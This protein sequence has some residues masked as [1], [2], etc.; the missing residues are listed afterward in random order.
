MAIIVGTFATAGFSSVGY[1]A[2]AQEAEANLAANANL[3]LTDGNAYVS[4]EGIRFAEFTNASPAKALF[5]AGKSKYFDL[6]FS[7][8]YE[9]TSSVDY[10]TIGIA[11]GMKEKD[12]GQLNTSA[13]SPEDGGR[14]LIM[15]G[16]I[17]NSAKCNARYLGGGTTQIV[18]TGWFKEIPNVNVI[19]GNEHKVTLS[20]KQSGDNFKISLSV[21]GAALEE[22]NYPRNWDGGSWKINCDDLGY[23]GLFTETNSSAGN[24]VIDISELKL[25]SYDDGNGGQIE[26]GNPYSFKKS[27][28]DTTNLAI[29][30]NAWKIA[31]NGKTTVSYEQGLRFDSFTSTASGKALFTQAKY[32]NFDLAVKFKYTD[33]S[34]VDDHKLLGVA[35]G[36]QSTDLAQL[37]IDGNTPSPQG[38]GRYA[39]VVGK[40]YGFE[41]A[42]WYRG[43]DEKVTDSGA[44]SSVTD[45]IDG[46][47]HSLRITVRKQSASSSD[48]WMNV[49][50]DNAEV[51]KNAYIHGKLTVDG[52]GTVTY[53]KPGYI[54]LF[55]ETNNNSGNTAVEISDVQIVSYDEKSCGESVKNYVSGANLGAMVRLSEPS[56]LRF[57][58]DLDKG[59]YNDMVTAYG[60]DN[61]TAGSVLLPADLLGENELNLETNGVEDIPLINWFDE[62][63]DTYTGVL[64]NIPSDKYGRQIAARSYIR[65]KLKNGLTKTYYGEIIERSVSF[66]ANAAYNDPNAGFYYQNEMLL[67]YFGN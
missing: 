26:T 20:V 42:Y 25:T 36:M 8:K 62:T 43:Y 37:T 31:D 3:W 58:F 63:S 52:C 29:N 13:Y 40:R 46:N 14:H 27:I 32:Q 49:Y 12:F 35:F 53:D 19:D 55:T 22:M 39:V 56:G 54:G 9:D 33:T 41:G 34:A 18:D 21:D 23:I 59:V 61:V 10:K 7:F 48:Y 1:T 60:S 17:Y 66:V 57:M 67:Q 65:V 64:T 51:Y 44:S 5:A 28:L 47:E 24:N 16:N 4:D 30:Q 45:I 50:I 11:F 38:E 2:Y 6:S 15:L